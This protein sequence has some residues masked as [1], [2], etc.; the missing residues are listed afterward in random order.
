MAGCRQ[1]CIE[2]V[3]VVSRLMVLVDRHLVRLNGEP[4][5]IYFKTRSVWNAVETARYPN[6]LRQPLHQ[7]H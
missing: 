2:H 7:V 1:G 4:L 3:A 5:V 6:S